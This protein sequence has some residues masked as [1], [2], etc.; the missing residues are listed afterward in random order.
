MANLTLFLTFFPFMQ[1]IPGA[2]AEVQPVA[3]IPALVGFLFYG[4]R[5]DRVTFFSTLL[6]SV[7]ISYSLA[8]L[9]VGTSLKQDILQTVAYLAPLVLFVYFRQEARNLNW[10]PVLAFASISLVVGVLQQTSTFFIIGDA[11]HLHALIPRMDFSPLTGARGITFMTPEPSHAARVLFQA[12]VLLPLLA[13]RR[14]STARL[15][16]KKLR[17]AALIGFLILLTRSATGM[18]LVLAVPVLY[19]AVVVARALLTGR[20]PRDIRLLLLVLATVLSIATLVSL[21]RHIAS[22]IRFVQIAKEVAKPVFWQQDPNVVLAS[23]GGKRLLTVTIGY[24]SLG[25]SLVG[26]GIASEKRVF[27]AME[28][29]TGIVLSDLP[30]RFGDWRLNPELKPD[31]YAASVAMDMG[32]PGLLALLALLG[33]ALRWGPR[34]HE[35][36][37]MVAYRV[38]VAAIAIMMIMFYSSSSLPVPWVLLAVATAPPRM[39]PESSVRPV[40]HPLVL[41]TSTRNSEHA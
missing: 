15:T 24:L 28:R 8:S 14:E 34:V 20:A 39:R 3:V 21:P 10:L 1:L 36:K 31:A 26:H 5:R 6:A 9:F 35:G 23:L 17:W 30:A 11:L 7:V 18:V 38:A 22:K 37:Q 25:N 12:A 2:R 13:P 29:Y 41:G 40:S 16:S 27:S 32:L 19:F 33:V 4:V